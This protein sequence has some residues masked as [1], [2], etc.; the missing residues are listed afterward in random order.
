MGGNEEGGIALVGAQGDPPG[1]WELHKR[2]KGIRIQSIGPK[3]CI[4]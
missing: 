1:E 3:M 2:M 4:S